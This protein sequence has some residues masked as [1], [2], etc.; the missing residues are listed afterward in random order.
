MQKNGKH[1]NPVHKASEA[2]KK[3]IKK[4]GK[5]HFART[6]LLTAS[7]IILRAKQGYP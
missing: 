6:A 2:Q 3:H 1:L 5:G 4:I 7:I